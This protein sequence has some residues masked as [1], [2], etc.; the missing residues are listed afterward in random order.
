MVSVVK[1]L[2]GPACFPFHGE[3]FVTK[4]EEIFFCEI[5]SRQG[6]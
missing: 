2:G 5:G 1:T 6:I 3:A 4:E